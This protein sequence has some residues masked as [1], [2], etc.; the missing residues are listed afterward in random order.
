MPISHSRGAATRSPASARRLGI[1][2]AAAVVIAAL[3]SLARAT[4]IDFS[5]TKYD[6]HGSFSFTEPVG[7]DIR[8]GNVTSFTFFY[9]TTQ[10]NGLLNLE[11]QSGSNE[12]IVMD[13]SLP[14]TV[15]YASGSYDEGGP[16]SL[17]T[18]SG[19]LTYGIG[20]GGEAIKLWPGGYGPGG[21]EVSVVPTP[22]PPSL[23][24]LAGAVLGL[25][26]LSRWRNG[27]RWTASSR[28]AT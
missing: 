28:V 12:L 27:R 22:E 8:T 6:I 16:G 1:L 5:D 14:F 25:I 13:T 15:F 7:S 23:A 20:P 4:T 11:Y 17:S 18:G 3:P 21:F 10:T 2:G 19:L 24:V 9:G 26:G